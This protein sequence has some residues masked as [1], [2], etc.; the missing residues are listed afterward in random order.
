MRPATGVRH[1]RLSLGDERSL[2]LGSLL[3]GYC[4]DGKLTYAGSVGTGWSHKLGR[5]IMAALQPSAEMAHHSSPCRART[6]FRP[7][8]REHFKRRS[9][10]GF[11]LP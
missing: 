3:V 2:D 7:P 6:L 8:Q 9:F 1:R 4:E 10:S 11:M 5:S